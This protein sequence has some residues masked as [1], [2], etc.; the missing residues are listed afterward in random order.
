[1][2]TDNEIE[3]L[4]ELDRLGSIKFISKERKELLTRLGITKHEQIAV[5]LNELKLAKSSPSATSSSPPYV[6]S[7]SWQ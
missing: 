7:L 2:A 1:M 4:E 6:T 5:K 3:V